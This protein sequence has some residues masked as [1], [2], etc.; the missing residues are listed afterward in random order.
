MY[1]VRYRRE[2]FVTRGRHEMTPWKEAE[3]VGSRGK[4]ETYKLV[5][6]LRR[7]GYEVTVKKFKNTTR[8]QLQGCY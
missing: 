2:K 6:Q 7:D 8:K 1:V 4:A 5:R 3:F